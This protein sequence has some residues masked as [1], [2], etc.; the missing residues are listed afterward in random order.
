V[1]ISLV[2]LAFSTVGTLIWS[3]RPENPIGWLFCSGAFLW[4][5]GE[6]A[7]EYGV[8]ALI[9]APGT[10]PA[11]TWAAWFGGWVRGI[12]WF[13]IVG[14]LLLL[15]P[16]GRLPSPRWR[17]VLW[18]AVGYVGFFTVVILLSP[19]SNDTR[20]AFVRNPLGL[21]IE[22]IDLLLELVYVT[23]PLLLV[24]GAAAVIVRFRRSRG[25]ERQQLKWFAYAVAVMIVC[26]CSGSRSRW[27]GS[28]RPALWCSP[29]PSWASR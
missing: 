14:F 28:W 17:P 2:L 19:A 5:L 11:G 18:G 27:W 13:L 21:K 25:E 9:T 23:I 24:A 4:I 12:G 6:L 3:R 1:F 10:L 22:L 7:L 8:Y 16:N 26:S 20:L 15:F 29:S